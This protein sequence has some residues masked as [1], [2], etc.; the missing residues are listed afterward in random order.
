MPTA[1][2]I[3]PD[4]T[5]CIDKT[6]PDDVIAAQ[7]RILADLQIAGLPT[8]LARPSPDC[9]RLRHAGRHTLATWCAPSPRDRAA[10]VAAVA[11]TVDALHQAGVV[12]GAIR[13]DHVVIAGTGAPVLVGL[14]SARR[15]TNPSALSSAAPPAERRDDIEALGLLCVAAS[16]DAGTPGAGLARFLST[17]RDDASTALH[18]VAEKIHAGRFDSARGVAVALRD[19]FGLDT[20]DNPMCPGPARRGEGPTACEGAPASGRP[21]STPTRTDRPRLTPTTPAGARRSLTATARVALG[22]FCVVVGGVALAM[23]V[24]ALARSSGRVP[25]DG[26][27]SFSAQDSVDTGRDAAPSGTPLDLTAA[28]P[29]NAV[30][31]DSDNNS[32]NDS[33]SDSDSDAS[34]ASVAESASPGCGTPGGHDVDGDGCPDDVVIETGAVI[35][36]GVRYTV[37]QPGDELAVGDWDCDGTA[38]LALVRA[39]AGEVWVFARWPEGEPLTATLAAE[40]PPPLETTVVTSPADGCESLVVRGDGQM[41]SSADP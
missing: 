21:H 39:V 7:T 8:V 19:A 1:L 13:P 23:G 29:Q 20:A 35:V 4:G 36:D 27:R 12:H 33:D 16:A 11:D 5:L 14:S 28:P 40:I 9:L 30:D 10:L 6:G 17:R 24:G 34:Q 3:A 32:N 41:W 2:V 18:R 31:S 26:S 38:T 15:V 25:A 22:A 37:G